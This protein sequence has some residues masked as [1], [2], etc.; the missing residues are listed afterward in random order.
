[1]TDIV[2]NTASGALTEAGAISTGSVG[3]IIIFFLAF[4]LLATVI[5]LIYSAISKRS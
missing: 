4:A 3:Q 1:M 2:N 5:G